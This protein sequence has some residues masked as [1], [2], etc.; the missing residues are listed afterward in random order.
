MIAV[1]DRMKSHCLLI[2]YTNCYCYYFSLLIINSD[3]W[4]FWKIADFA[5]IN[6]PILWKVEYGSPFIYLYYNK[7]EHFCY[8]Y[9][10]F[11]KYYDLLEIRKIE[12]CEILWKVSRV[13]L[14]LNYLHYSELK[15]FV[16]I[17]GFEN[18]TIRKFEKFSN[19]LKSEVKIHLSLL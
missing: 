2:S 11:W 13:S 8:Y 16:I 4:K 9:P 7:L 18:I 14:T 3:F 5:D 10:P 17:H 1:S 15:I 12:F 6:F 19:S